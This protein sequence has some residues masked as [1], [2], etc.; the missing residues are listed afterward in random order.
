MSA[1][2]L[3]YI[4]FFA[5]QI[6]ILSGCQG[7]RW[8]LNEQPV[9]TPPA[10]FT[11]YEI[12]D[13]Q[14]KACVQETILSDK[15]TAAEQLIQLSCSYN[16]ISSTQGLSVFTQLQKLDLSHNQLNDIDALKLINQL[17]YID[18]SANSLLSCNDIDR[19]RGH[20]KGTLKQDS[21]SN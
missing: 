4:V 13:A 11:A 1:K 3:V 14:L 20:Y 17:Q 7:Y 8:T 15:I 12:D 19:L 18:I 21:C 10:L 9:Y 6:T 5:L 16:T 2:S